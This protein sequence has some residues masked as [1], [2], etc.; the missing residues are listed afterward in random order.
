MYKAEREKNGEA[1]R[2]SLCTTG[3]EQSSHRFNIAG[4]RQ[5]VPGGFPPTPVLGE[6]IDASASVKFT[7]GPA[8]PGVGCVQGTDAATQATS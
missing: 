7:V 6:E 4:A 3:K 8:A 2:P 5:N 1:S